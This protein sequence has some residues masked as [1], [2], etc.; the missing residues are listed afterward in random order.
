MLQAISIYFFLTK[1]KA[2]KK[3]NIGSLTHDIL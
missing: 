1:E 2:A 3:W